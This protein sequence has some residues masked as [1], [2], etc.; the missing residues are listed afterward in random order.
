VITPGKLDDS[1]RI[2]KDLSERMGSPGEPG[3]DPMDAM[4]SDDGRN[5]SREERQFADLFHEKDQSAGESINS[6]PFEP[7]SGRWAESPFAMVNAPVKE[8]RPYE[9]AED[10]PSPPAKQESAVEAD[11]VRFEGE[12][13]PTNPA[14]PAASTRPARPKPAEEPEP[15]IP[16]QPSGDRILQGFFGQPPAPLATPSPPSSSSNQIDRIEQLAERLA[17]RVLVSDRTYAT[18]SEVRIQLRESVLQGAEITIRRDQGQLVVSF[19][20]VNAHLA[21]QLLP[22]TDDLQRALATRLDTTVRIEVNVSSGETGGQGSP[23]DGRS[24]NR[25]DPRDEWGAD[26]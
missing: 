6:R 9:D 15:S 25:R 13:K 24:R 26:Y 19:N 5:L 21:Q 20:G 22:Q 10:F 2:S 7:H 14:E 23:G 3:S 4:M 17:E 18:D 12:P 11:D 16:V 1:L 8:T